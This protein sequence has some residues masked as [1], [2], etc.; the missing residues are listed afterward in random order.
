MRYEIEGVGF[1][2][3]DEVLDYIGAGGQ[4]NLYGVGGTAIK[5]YHKKDW[6]IDQT[7]FD[8]LKVMSSHPR[9]VAPAN[10]VKYRNSRVGY[11]MKW[12]KGTIP[13]ASAISNGFWADN[14]IDI[15]LANKVVASIFD[16]TRTILDF[17]TIKCIGDPNE[18]NWLLDK[19]S[20]EVVYAIDC[21]AY[22]T[23]S[24][25]IPSAV[26]PTVRDFTTSEFNHL[27]DWYGIAVITFMWYTGIN[28]YMGR[29][30]DYTK[31]QF[32]ERV[33]A[34]AAVIDGKCRINPNI[35]HWNKIPTGLFSWYEAVF[36]NGERCEPP[37]AFGTIGAG[38]VTV[39]VMSKKLTVTDV[40][41][42]TSNIRYH[43]FNKGK[44]R[45][46][47]VKENDSL[48]TADGKE[49]EIKKSE[50][51]LTISN[52]VIDASDGYT[53]VDGELFIFQY[54]RL[55]KIDL[56]TFSANVVASIGKTW[57]VVPNSSTLYDG[58]I[59]SDIIGNQYLIVP[60]TNDVKNIKVPE[61]AKHKITNARR[62][63]NVV[64]VIAYDYASNKYNRFIFVIKD[65]TYQC[66]TTKDI[67]DTDINFTLLSNGVLII[68]NE[69]ILE[70]RNIRDVN[71][72]LEVKDT[73]L[74]LG[75]R[76]TSEGE[77]AM[78]IDGNVLQIMR[79]N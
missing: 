3:V 74:P 16:L 70:V 30:P 53:I 41:Q 33:L 56:Q 47:L 18:F 15:A 10:Y 57:D 8:E 50:T 62:Q 21:D 46:I 29:H 22:G 52:L 24:Y 64:I 35:R 61:L 54:D 42:Y 17:E 7:K 45:I 2:E 11:A 1:I 34:G 75:V 44:R 66:I 26:S 31:D 71:R 78:L 39:K 23:K 20:L 72:V 36:L 69:D 6:V 4:A 28:P 59:I 65:E 13:L 76:L 9:I 12:A 49:V 55:I 27:T 19:N 67:S 43:R 48:M 77:H 51:E 63:G 40:A 14:N 58:V 73:G 25:P 79:L 68:L 37:K 32:K 5:H 38:K 60:S